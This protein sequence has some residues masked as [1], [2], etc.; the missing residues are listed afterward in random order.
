LAATPDDPALT[1]HLAGVLAAEDKAEALPLLDKLHTA[2]PA[3]AAITR[4]LAEVL[5]EAGD[6]A[7]SDRLYTALL[8]A[9]PG[10]V[11]LLVAHGQ[12]LIQQ[13][14]NAEAFAAFDKA[15]QIDPANADGW[16]GLAFAA[17]R[18]ER[19]SVA[20]HALAMRSKYLAELP[21]TCFLWAISY[22][23]LHDKPQAI[24]YYHRFLDAAA[25][26]FPD[27]EWQARQR[28]KLLEK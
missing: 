15:T 4:M 5:A 22:D 13:Q 21:A 1:A 2:H 26:K 27:Q 12:N 8:A 23:S 19:P 7:G 20:I 14:K 24:R 3:D 11:L 9:N 16:S 28:L 10:D 17:S 6:A 25:G 18:T